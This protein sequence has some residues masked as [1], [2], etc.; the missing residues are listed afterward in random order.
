MNRWRNCC[1]TSSIVCQ[2]RP[3]SIHHTEGILIVYVLYIHFYFFTEAQE[4][5]AKVTFFLRMERE[6]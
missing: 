6:L 2:S 3:F 5:S 1:D 4:Q